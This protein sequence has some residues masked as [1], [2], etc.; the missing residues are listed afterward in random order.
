M[1]SQPDLHTL[2]GQKAAVYV[3]RHETVNVL[4]YGVHLSNN[5][6]PQSARISQQP[7]L[8]G[9]KTEYA[10]IKYCFSEESE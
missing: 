2:K 7:V 8:F 1:Q 10:N 4:V 9:Y 5:K 6:N 3:S